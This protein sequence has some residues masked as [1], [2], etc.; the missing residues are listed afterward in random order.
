VSKTSSEER[1]VNGPVEDGGPLPNLRLLRVELSV[2]EY[3]RVA[4]N[5]LARPY[6]PNPNSPFLSYLD[7]LPSYVIARCP[8][9]LE[10]NVEKI[11]TYS[12]RTWGGLNAGDSVF[13]SRRST[14]CRHF[15]LAQTFFHFHGIWPTGARISVGPEVPYVIGHLLE[16]GWCQAVI[17]ALPVCRIE[18]NTFVPRY[19]LFMVSYFSSV[20]KIAYKV[21][22]DHNRPYGE[23]GVNKVFLPN[24]VR[25][26]WWDLRQ[27]VSA[28][29]L[30]WMD[31]SDPDLP[32]RTHDAEA[33]PYGEIT[34]RRFFH[35]F[36]YPFPKPRKPRSRRKPKKHGEG[37]DKPAE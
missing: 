32:I 13:S 12:I 10:E 5:R 30:H 1:E 6:L 8:L 27:W 24:V 37:R 23:V 2:G 25:E 26:H 3:E 14:Y 36:P 31:G 28:G 11:D 15:A 34:G 7:K 9:C 16:D 17:H 22:L 33:F 19:T 21:L 18:D 29:L 20:P 4:S 35:Q